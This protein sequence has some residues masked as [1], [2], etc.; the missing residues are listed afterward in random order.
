[1]KFTKRGGVIAVIAL[2]YP[3]LLFLFMSSSLAMSLFAFS[4]LFGLPAYLLV[5]IMR[6]EEA[7]RLWIPLGVNYVLSFSYIAFLILDM[8]FGVA[9]SCGIVSHLN[10]HTLSVLESLISSGI[11][12]VFSY[13]GLPLSIFSLSVVKHKNKVGKMFS[14]LRV[15]L[16][17]VVLAIAGVML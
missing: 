2:L 9:A 12:T 13:Q 17:F 4:V 11:I 14:L 1:M 7:K 8:F 6:N 10:T 5:F 16:F 15:V 3:F